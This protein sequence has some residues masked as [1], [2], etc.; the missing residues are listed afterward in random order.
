MAQSVYVDNASYSAVVF[1]RLVESQE[2]LETEVGPRAELIRSGR[3]GVQQATEVLSQEFL[4]Q[5]SLEGHMSMVV[6]YCGTYKMPY[7][8]AVD[9]VA[10]LG[11][12]EHLAHHPLRWIYQEDTLVDEPSRT[13]SSSSS[14]SLR[15]IVPEREPVPV[16]DLSDDE[17]VE[18]LEM[19]PV[20]SGIWLGTLIEEDPSE[21]MSD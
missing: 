13:T 5:I 14:Y 20:A 21:P 6:F 17:S 3:S 8:T 7:S 2:G 12:S 18:G 9:L 1:G 10:G 19:A 4:D 15:E 11:I 16:I